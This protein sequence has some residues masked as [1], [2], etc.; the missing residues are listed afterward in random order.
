MCCVGLAPSNIAYNIATK[1]SFWAKQRN[2]GERSATSEPFS[3][4]SIPR[5]RM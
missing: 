4:C 5:N 2:L 3:R 1:W